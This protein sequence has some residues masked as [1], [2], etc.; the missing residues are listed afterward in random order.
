M[1]DP[2]S[3]SEVYPPTSMAFEFAFERSCA[4]RNDLKLLIHQV[5]DSLQGRQAG[6]QAGR[7]VDGGQAVWFHYYLTLSLTHMV[8]T[9]VSSVKL[10]AT[11][12]DTHLINVFRS[13]HPSGERRE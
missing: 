12:Y 5:C 2:G 10:I 9:S 4:S 3:L 13:Q 7:L 1:R 11:S 8:P 6:R